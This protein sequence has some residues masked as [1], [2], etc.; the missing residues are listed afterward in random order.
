MEDLVFDA[1]PY[2]ARGQEP[3]PYIVRAVASLKPGQALTLLNT[4]D[5]RPLEAVMEARG[6]QYTVERLGPELFRVRFTRVA[7][8]D[9]CPTVDRRGQPL[10]RVLLQLHGIVRKLRVGEQFA[11]RLSEHPG[12]ALKVVE[13]AGAVVDVGPGEPG[14]VRLVVTRVRSS[15]GK[16]ARATAS[17]QH[18]PDGATS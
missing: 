14:E 15:D 8:E 13:R 18:S 7:A 12:P 9:K 11:V 2:Q 5:P 3:Y 1:R 16:P 4:F 17:S 10:E 6:F